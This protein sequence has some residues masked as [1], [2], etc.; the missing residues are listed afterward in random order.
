MVGGAAVGLARMAWGA[1]MGEAHAEVSPTMI[2]VAAV[3]L[4]VNVIFNTVER[5]ED[6]RLDSQVLLADAEHT[7]S[8]GSCRSQY[9]PRAPAS[10]GNDENDESGAEPH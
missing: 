1:L 7:L 10:S 6:R 4:V 3:T 2:V 9:S 5:R 8:D